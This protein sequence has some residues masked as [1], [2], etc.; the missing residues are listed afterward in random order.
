MQ[1]ATSFYG[2]QRYYVIIRVTFRNISHIVTVGLLLLPITNQIVFCHAIYTYSSKVYKKC[3]SGRLVDFGKRTISE[4]TSTCWSKQHIC[5]STHTC[6][7][8]RPEL[9]IAHSFT[10]SSQGYLL[11][12][13]SVFTL[14]AMQNTTTTQKA[15]KTLPPS[16]THPQTWP[17]PHI[18]T[19]TYRQILT[20]C[21]SLNCRKIIFHHRQIITICF[22]LNSSQGRKLTRI[23]VITAHRMYVVFLMHIPDTY[24]IFLH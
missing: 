14:A 7:D 4:R 6:G 16:T 19:C 13:Q 24:S 17:K 23:R 3:I 10:S 2:V 1:T 18:C 8:A 20:I 9:N 21:F 5:I 22:S 11:A 12:R 15:A